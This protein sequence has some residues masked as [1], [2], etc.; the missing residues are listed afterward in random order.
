[1]RKIIFLILLAAMLISCGEQKVGTNLSVTEPEPAN[2]DKTEE[3][4]AT[5]NHGLEYMDLGGFEINFIIRG[6]GLVAFKN[7]DLYAESINGDVINDAIYERNTYLEETYN[8]KI[9]ATAIDEPDYPAVVLRRHIQAGEHIYDVCYDSF[10]WSKILIQENMLT[11]LFSLPHIDF[12]K[13]YW[14]E[15]VNSDLTIQNK[16]FITHGE[17][18][19]SLRAGLYGVFFN[20]QLAADYQL[21]NLYDVV[22][23]NRWTID[24]YYSLAKGLSRDLNNDGKMDFNDFWGNATEGYYALAFYT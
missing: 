10:L 13:P 3:A 16:L 2:E 15:N 7:V 17:H 12:S 14:D 20:K 8:F 23:D 5:K 21:E 1:M 11:D 22:R 18:M 9:K 24:K 4:P 19:L 6:E